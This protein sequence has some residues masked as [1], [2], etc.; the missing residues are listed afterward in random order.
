MDEGV[1]TMMATLCLWLLGCREVPFWTTRPMSS[2][3][4]T[5]FAARPEYASDGF[6]F[7]VGPPDAVGFYD[8]QPFGVNDHSGE[9]WNGV[10]G[11][12]SDL[13]EPIYAMAN[14]WVSEAE[15][16][17]GGWCNVVRIVHL[18]D[19]VFFESI[20]AHHETM[21]KTAGE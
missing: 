6:D 14:G 9:D 10:R 15:D 20:Y 19:G 4:A 18:V 3:Y 13:G 17:G 21:F 5:L 11:G 16:Q 12:D 1:F 7:P 2:N 8:A